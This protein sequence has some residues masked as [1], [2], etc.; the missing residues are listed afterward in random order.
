MRGAV[1]G[2]RSKLTILSQIM[3]NMKKTGY[4]LVGSFALL[5]L[6]GQYDAQATFVYNSQT[7]PHRL[8]R[9]SERGHAVAYYPVNLNDFSRP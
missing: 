4:A 2:L 3:R 8:G 5:C 9:L 6:A 1:V 7:D